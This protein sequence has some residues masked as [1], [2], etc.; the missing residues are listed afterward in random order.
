MIEITDEEIE[1]AEQVLL[2]GKPFDPERREFIRDMKTLDLHAVPGSGKTTVLLAKLLILDRHLPFA[3]GSGILVLSHTN[4]TVDEIKKKLQ[5]LCRHLFNYPNFVGTIQ[6]FTNEFL[7]TPYYVQCYSQ[8][9]QNIG[10]DEYC[11]AMMRITKS[12]L[13][14]ETIGTFKKILQIKNANENLLNGYRFSALGNGNFDLVSKL[15]GKKLEAKKPKP[16]NARNYADWNAAEKDAVYKYLVKVKTELLK[17]GNLHFDDVFFLAERY[18]LKYPR[19]CEFLRKRFPHVFIDEMQDMEKHQHDLLEKLFFN[20]VN[21]VT[22]FQRIGDT[23]QSIHSEFSSS[24]FGW[25]PRENIKELKGSFRLSPLIAKAVQPFGIS[26][27]AIEGRGKQSNGDEIALRPHLLVFNDA[28]IEKVIEKFSEIVKRFQL[29]GEIPSKGDEE[30]HAV[31]WVSK[32]NDKNDRLILKS[33]FEYQ[34]VLDKPKAKYDHLECYLKYFDTK[35][36]SLRGIRNNIISAL[37]EVLKIEGKKYNEKRWFNNSLLDSIMGSGRGK[38]SN[39]CFNRYE[40]ILF[41]CSMSVIRG[42]VKEAL[43]VLRVY[44]KNVFLL[45]FEIDGHNAHEFI[46]G[47]CALLVNSTEDGVAKSNT[48]EFNGLTIQVG[49]VHSQKGRT[50][51]ATLYMETSFYGVETARTSKQ[52]RGTSHKPKGSDKRIKQSL[53]M[54]YVGFSR[55]THLLCFAVHEKRLKELLDNP[56]VRTHWDVYDSLIVNV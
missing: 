21:S 34:R 6:S 47:P 52:F 30:F 42:E 8:K 25:K 41:D 28:S 45:L 56:E 18:I 32:P 43:S 1:F 39:D 14:G 35:D 5:P 27:I 51:T 36:K 23:N 13:A 55:P 40:Q 22:C 24:D 10:H 50:H 11:D 12:C 48:K 49:T 7:G 4:H 38:F 19:A 37:V 16:R 15:N 53:R 46:N 9:I 20:G 31:A 3:D 26:G 29:S 33:Y 44:I 54:A 17:R 2:N